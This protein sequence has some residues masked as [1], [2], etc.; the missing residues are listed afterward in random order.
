MDVGL[1]G[2]N[3]MYLKVDFDI[4]EERTTSSFIPGDVESIFFLKRWYLSTSPHGFATSKISVDVLLT[5]VRTLNFI[6]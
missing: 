5:T 6:N 3:A 4:S 2:G 1:L